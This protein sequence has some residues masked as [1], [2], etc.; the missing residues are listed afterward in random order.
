MIVETLLTIVIKVLVKAWVSLWI[1]VIIGGVVDTNSCEVGKGLT[2]KER[3]GQCSMRQFK[4]DFAG[5]A[6]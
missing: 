3:I 5:M 4:G 2:G 1:S 6:G